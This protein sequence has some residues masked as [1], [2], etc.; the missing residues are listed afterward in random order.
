MVNDT[1]ESYIKIY[2]DIIPKKICTTSIRELK[3]ESWNMHEFYDTKTD[4]MYHLDKELSVSYADNLSTRECL[5]KLI[6][7]SLEN[8]I[9]KDLNYPWFKG[10]AG[11][12]PIRFN[13][14]EKNTQMNLHWDS[15]HSAFDGTVKGIPMLSIIGV[16][17]DDYEGGELIMRD[18]Q[19]KLD[20]GDILVFP[21]SFMYP[22]YVKEVTKGTRYS[23][24]SWAY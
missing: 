1:L 21:S 18:K 9:L 4:S 12:T 24:V 5:M 6:F 11:Y 2:K 7:N 13:K 8:Y 15:I 3:K 17:N 22:H 10:W 23:F 19:V 14:Y 16:L 20:A